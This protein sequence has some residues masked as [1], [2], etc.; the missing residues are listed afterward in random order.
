MTYIDDGP[1]VARPFLH[2]EGPQTTKVRKF[3]VA[4]TNDLRIIVNNTGDGI[5]G[6]P[7]RK[8]RGNP[9]NF[10]ISAVVRYD[11]PD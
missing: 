1:N 2:G 9:T 5:F 8:I 11:T 4:G 3:L 7:I 10:G 6:G